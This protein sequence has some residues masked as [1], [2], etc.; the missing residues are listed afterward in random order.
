MNYVFSHEPC[1]NVKFPL[2][3]LWI[4]TLKLFHNY[5]HDYVLIMILR[6]N[7]DPFVCSFLGLKKK[8]RRILTD[9]EKKRDKVGQQRD[10]DKLTVFDFENVDSDIQSHRSLLAAV[11]NGQF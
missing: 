3:N 6:S 1:T 8:N 4:T 7:Y 11:I 9:K 2:C 5:V 10:V